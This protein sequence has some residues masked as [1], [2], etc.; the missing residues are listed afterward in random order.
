MPLGQPKLIRRL[1]R[2]PSL[3]DSTTKGHY[4]N[5]NLVF[6]ASIRVCHAVPT[7]YHGYI[8]EEKFWLHSFL[9]VIE[10]YEMRRFYYHRGINIAWVRESPSY[11][12][13]YGYQGALA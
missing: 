7:C 8:Y 2:I 13:S 3:D 10:I 1:Q 12:S 5:F 11:A 6:K 9:K 4:T